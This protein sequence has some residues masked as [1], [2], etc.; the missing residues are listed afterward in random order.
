MTFVSG[1]PRT[2]PRRLNAFLSILDGDRAGRPI[3]LNEES[4]NLIGRGT[5]CRIVLTDPLASRIHAAIYRAGD[6]WFVRD[7]SSRNGT[8]LDG[9]KIEQ[10]PLRE[11]GKIRIGSTNMRF[12]GAVQAS[13]SLDDDDDL[14][15]TQ[16]LNFGAK[17]DVKR[18][19]GSLRK[20]VGVKGRGPDTDF[21]RF[22]D[23]SVRLLGNSDPDDV[24]RVTLEDLKERTKATV[25]GFLWVDEGRLK[26][27]LAIPEKDAHRAVLS[28]ELTQKVIREQNAIRIDCRDSSSAGR[29]L[30]AF[31]EAICVP[32]IYSE[33]TLGAIHLYKA[34]GRFEDADFD[35]AI[36][37]ANAMVIALVRAREQALLREENARLVAKNA[38]Q[39]ELVGESKPMVELLDKIKRIARA[40]G[41]VLIRGESGS[42]K[43]LVA[44]ALHRMS[45]RADRPMLSVNCAAIPAELM[46]SQLF[47]HKKG[48]FTSADAD[49]PGYF[50]QADTGTLFL[51]EVGELTLEGQA[52]LLR[53][54]EGHSFL[55]V[56]GVK[57][58]S[59]DVRVLAATNR[60]LRE[61]VR[62]KKFREDLYYRL[63]VFELQ[64][65]PLRDRGTDVGLLVDHF[66]EHFKRQHGR[67]QLTLTPAA[68]DRLI[69][70]SW[71]GNVRQL[72]N[73]I[74]SAVVMADSSTIDPEDLGLRDASTEES[75]DDL[76]IDRWEKKLI[77]RAL[78]RTGGGVP[79][80]AKLLGI[81]RATLYRKL[82]EYDLKR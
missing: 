28:K 23:L 71:P 34:G 45:P 12:S 1:R 55:P 6:E 41:C 22:S 75:A 26:P 38:D 11:G 8:F 15:G 21:I 61:F 51:D 52:K 54:L 56:G 70:Y 67:L 44:R 10:A 5:E 50:R 4:E 48:S 35:Y 7:S 62:E 74:D 32:L 79:Q 73:V 49:H 58:V 81:S 40:S 65:P 82:E 16:T 77:E 57:E 78:S 60:D 46:E 2:T 9:R 72:R 63:S 36:L 59:V 43:E 14:S 19:A 47:G 37:V 69:A 76:R 53:I 68:R 17:V 31:D 33:E 66:F 39:G 42:G 64:I 80:A 25:I 29:D 18:S 27:K 24:V 20:P 30:A 3:P 13:R